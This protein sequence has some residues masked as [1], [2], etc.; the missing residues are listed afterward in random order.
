MQSRRLLDVEAQRDL[1]AGAEAMPPMQGVTIMSDEPYLAINW[2]GA[3]DADRARVLA[4]INAAFTAIGSTAAE[5]A[6][7]SFDREAEEFEYCGEEVGAVM[8]T[9][10]DAQ[11]EAADLW[12]TMERVALQAF[13]MDPDRDRLPDFIGWIEPW[14]TAAGAQRAVDSWHQ[15]R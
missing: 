12:M 8:P 15:F 2:A 9:V 14:V 3:A 6:R 4:A 11:H 5:G 13:G 7:A 1:P 10:T